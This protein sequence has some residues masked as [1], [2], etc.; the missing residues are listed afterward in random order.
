MLLHLLA[1]RVCLTA[2]IIIGTDSLYTS[3]H[4]KNQISSRK[5][6]SHAQFLDHLQLG[7]Q[8][9]QMHIITRLSHPKCCASKKLQRV[10]NEEARSKNSYIT[11]ST[12][13][14][15]N[16]S[17]KRHLISIGFQRKRASN[18]QDRTQRS[19]TNELHT[20]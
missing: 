19:L 20:W 5:F 3:P 18:R 9:H 14:T 13:L 4:H 17:P 7:Q 16:T 8:T 10:H 11:H 2:P 6:T 12:Q 15:L 1:R